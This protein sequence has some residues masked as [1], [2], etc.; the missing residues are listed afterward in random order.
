MMGKIILIEILFLTNIF[1]P[2]FVLADQV[3]SH[4]QQVTV[5][6][7]TMD[8]TGFE[9]PHADVIRGPVLRVP[10]AATREKIFNETKITSKIQKLNE[11]E[12]N[13]LYYTAAN[14]P[15][16]TLHKRY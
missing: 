10:E 8:T 3:D 14:V 16:D 15:V 9:N 7:P 5:L 6:D 12:R 11:E 2:I 1:S 4:R 13:T